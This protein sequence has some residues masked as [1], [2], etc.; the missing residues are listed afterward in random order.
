MVWFKADVQKI[1]IVFF[2]SCNNTIEIILKYCH[3]LEVY[4]A[5]LDMLGTYMD[6]PI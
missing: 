5:P 6:Y 1:F 2:P 3:L 4:Y